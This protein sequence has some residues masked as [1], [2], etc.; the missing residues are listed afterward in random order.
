MVGVGLLTHDWSD[1]RSELVVEEYW[2]PFIKETK[3]GGKQ[4]CG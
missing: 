1:W 3:N 4:L 2:K